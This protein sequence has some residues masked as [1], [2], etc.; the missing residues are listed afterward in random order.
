MASSS[1]LSGRLEP[2]GPPS[3][4][5]GMDQRTFDLITRSFEAVETSREA[6]A[7]CKRCVAA[8]EAFAVAAGMRLHPPVADRGTKACPGLTQLRV[9]LTAEPESH[10]EVAHVVVID[11]TLEHPL[12]AHG[13]ALRKQFQRVVNCSVGF[14]EDLGGGFQGLHTTSSLAP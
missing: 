14:S 1:F 9:R 13:S 3:G 2:L 8:A 5:T 6:V 10:R 7:E 12:A 4:S 11:V